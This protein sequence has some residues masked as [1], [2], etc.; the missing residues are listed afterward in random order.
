MKFHEIADLFPMMGETDFKELVADIA[1]QGLLNAIIT[2]E[3]KILDG[4]NRYLA[5]REAGVEP[6]YEDYDGD[7]PLAYVVAQNLHRRHLTPSQRAMVVAGLADFT[8]GGNRSKA[9][10]CALKSRDEDA[11]QL[12]VSPRSVDHASKVLRKGSPELIAAVKAGEVAVSKAAEIADLPIEKQA[13]Y[14]RTAFAANDEWYTPAEYIALARE[15]MGC[16]DLDPATNELAQETVQAE[17]FFVA[18]D[19]GLAQPWSG[20]VWLNPPY[21]KGL[22]GQFVDKLCE[23]YLAGEVSEAIVL[24]NNFTDARWFHVLAATSTCLCLTRG[25][26]QFYNKTGQG[27]SPTNGHVFFYF[28]KNPSEFCRLFEPKGIILKDG[29][30]RRWVS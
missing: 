5:C 10:I 12:G 30:S 14:F 18:N 22:M 2:Y 9:Q 27:R 26:I 17:T 1:A 28:G 13:K 19:D 21:S 7:D 24:T 3:G 4:R 15:V 25:R 20:R 8:W 23:E 11:D 29:R 16:I 6:A